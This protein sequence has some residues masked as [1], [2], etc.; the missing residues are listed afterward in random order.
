M[1]FSD[2]IL[3]QM[4]KDWH[5]AAADEVSAYRWKHFFGRKVRQFLG[6]LRMD[7]LPNMD[8]IAG[9]VITGGNIEYVL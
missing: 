2:S 7:P 9:L 6:P 3:L 4:A 1:G 8:W 5:S